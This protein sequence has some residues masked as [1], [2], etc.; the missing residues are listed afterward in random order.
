MNDLRASILRVLNGDSVVGAAFLVTE[1]LVVTCSH[2]VKSAGGKD[3]RKISVGLPN[4]KRISARVERKYQKNANNEDITILRLED[5]PENMLPVAFGNSTNTKGHNFS[6]FGFPQKSQEL[7]GSGEIIGRAN[8]EGVD[9]LQLRS[10]EIT[11]GFSGAPVFDEITK[12]VVG[13]IVAITPPDKYHRLG[14]TAFAVPSEAIQNIC[15]ELQILD[16]CPYRSLNAFTENDA[17]FFFGRTLVIEHLVESLKRNPRFLAVLG[18]SGSGKSSVVMA[19]LIPALKR[20][21]IS[22]SEKWT[23]ITIRPANDP[24]EQLSVANFP[25]PQKGFEA[26]IKTWIRTQKQNVRLVLIVDQFEEIFV[27]CS[28]KMR[29]TLIIELEALLESSTSVTVIIVMRDDFYSR[30]Q[31]D[32]TPLVS[33]LEH[34]LINIPPTLTIDELREIVEKPSQ[35]AGLTFE[36]GLIETILTDARGIASGLHKERYASSTILPLLEFTL[37]QLWERHQDALLTHAAYRTIGGVTGGLAQ[38]ADRS[39]YSLSDNDRNLARKILCEL[40]HPGDESQGIPDSRQIRM[41]RDVLNINSERSL[42][43][44]ARLTDER[45]L[46]TRRN[47]QSGESTVE[48]IHDAL[49]SEWGLL[50]KWLAED[51]EFIKWKNE[52]RESLSSW[53]NKDRDETLLVGGVQLTNAEIWL[54]NRYEDLTEDERQYILSSIKL[55]DLLNSQ[56]KLGSMY[57]AFEAIVTATTEASNEDELIERATRL[58]GEQLH[59]D[60]FGILLLDE[61]KNE[62]YLHSSYLLGKSDYPVRIPVSMGITGSVARSG[63][64]RYVNDVRTVPDYVNVDDRIQSELCLPLKVGKRVIGVVNTES[65]ELDAFTNDEQE[66]LGILST[67]L[68]VGIQR[69]RTAKAEYNQT[70]N[71]MRANALIRILA[72][73][74]ARASTAS[75]PAGVMKL[76]GEELLKIGLICLVALPKDEQ[77]MMIAYTSIPRRVVTMIERVSKHTISDFL[78]PSK[79][80]MVYSGQ[81][82]HPILMLDPIASASNILVDFPRRALEKILRPIGVTENIPL[83]HLPL[84]SA[85][86]LQGILWLGGEGLRESDLPTMSIFASQVAIALRNSRLLAEVRRLDNADIPQRGGQGR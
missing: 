86:E 81:N 24:L 49:L 26:S 55:R 36:K 4:G 34:S 19:G 68:A 74:G 10:T 66:L 83:C 42:Q 18:P 27:S 15:P 51:R 13:M 69:L 82:P 25:E 61:E 80:L 48:I 23:P 65:A 54:K 7:T 1:R 84:V 12:R 20:G 35:I 32:A 31:R 29:D 11:S 72:Q 62:L 78:I 6:T 56:R 64:Q 9:V 76:L 57:T 71:L 28:D 52:L 73:V 21:E 63:R 77:Y 46:V 59:P 40:I 14:A 75:D 3:G 47:T 8:V 79:R 16:V 58:I 39:Y 50:K 41:L 45:L 70:T 22:S 2:I 38:W 67:Q 30:F 43:V 60:N 17:T 53:Y 37:T 44:I 33:W 85:G 5:S